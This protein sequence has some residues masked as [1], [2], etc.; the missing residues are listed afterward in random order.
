MVVRQLSGFLESRGSC[1]KAFLEVSRLKENSEMVAVMGLL[2]K[3]YKV[4]LHGPATAATISR[5]GL[6]RC[7]SLTHIMPPSPL[8]ASHLQLAW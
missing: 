6:R 2:A 4:H 3:K 8:P 7:M 5:C 1:A